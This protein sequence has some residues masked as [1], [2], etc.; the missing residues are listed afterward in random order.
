MSGPVLAPAHVPAKGAEWLSRKE[1]GGVVAI[2]LTVFL[3]TVFGRTLTRLVARLVAL[4]YVLT[5]P[6]ARAGL[7]AFYLRLEGRAPS[8]GRLYRH[9]LRFVFSTLDAFFLASGKT[10][11]FE[12]TRNGHQHLEA[13]RVAKKGAILLGAHVGSFYAMRI[14][15]HEEGLRL[16]ALMHTKNARMLNDALE[17]LDPEGAARVV[18]LDPEGGMDSMLKVKE[19]LE[20]GALVAILGDRIPPGA[21]EDRIVRVPFLGAEAAFPAGPL[22]LAATLKCPVYLTFGLGRG[23]NTYDLFCEPFAERIEL[24]RGRRKEALAEWVKKYAERLEAFVRRSPENWFNFYD[25]WR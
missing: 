19:L 18:E 21:T 17:K 25:F 5:S 4:Y 23:A 20:S 12:V 15:G 3:V 22:L 1:R 7:R 13:L 16:F 10:R 8:F 14:Q 24:P 9:F 11:G 2:R 6:S